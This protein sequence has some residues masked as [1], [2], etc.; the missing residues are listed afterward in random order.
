MKCHLEGIVYVAGTKGKRNETAKIFP[1]EHASIGSVPLE[2]QL[3]MKD[4]NI[5]LHAVFKQLILKS[6]PEI[7][8]SNK[9][10]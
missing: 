8:S 7:L 2:P 3:L 4:T 9:V 10:E 5:C 1:G 6:K